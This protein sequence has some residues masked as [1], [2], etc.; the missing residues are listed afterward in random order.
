MPVLNEFVLF[1]QQVGQ[2]MMRADA[3]QAGIVHGLFELRGGFT[4]VSGGFDLLETVVV[5][6]AQRTVEVFRQHLAHGVKLNAERQ[7]PRLAPY[8][9]RRTQHSP[10]NRG[11]GCGF[12]ETPSRDLLHGPLAPD[13]SRAAV[14]HCRR[15]VEI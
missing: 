13:R 6:L 9:R 14:P 15:A 3:A 7:M 4:E 8:V 5:Q 2:S 10:A 1:R 12:Y 11:S